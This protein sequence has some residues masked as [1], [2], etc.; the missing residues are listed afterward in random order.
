MAESDVG[1]TTF[2]DNWEFGRWKCFKQHFE[3]SYLGVL[4][5]IK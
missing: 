3:L 5:V 2:A 1:R 4:M